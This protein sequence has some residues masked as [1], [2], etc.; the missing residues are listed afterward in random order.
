MDSI[1]ITLQCTRMSL[2]SEIGP[3]EFLTV[4]GHIKSG[5]SSS[6]F[7]EPIH[8]PRVRIG[9]AGTMALTLTLTLTKLLLTT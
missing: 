6:T 4:D 9:S 3:Y 2:I 8:A 1:Y 7:S 5:G